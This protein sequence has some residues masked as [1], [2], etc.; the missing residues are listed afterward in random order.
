MGK[1]KRYRL[2]AS[3]DIGGQIKQ[4]A[5]FESPIEFYEEVKCI[6]NDYHVFV[7]IDT[8]TLSTHVEHPKYIT[9]PNDTQFRLQ[10]MLFR[11]RWF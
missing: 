9:K 5:C 3:E 4:L 8:N 1:T 6:P 11:S 2:M 10:D 7:L